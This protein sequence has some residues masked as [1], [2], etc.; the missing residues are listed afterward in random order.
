MF[1]AHQ[2]GDCFNRE[3]FFKARALTIEATKQI[4]ALVVPGMTE[5]DGHAL[6]NEVLA[7][8]GATKFW[9]P[10]KF[11]IGPNT[12]MSFREAST[13]GIKLKSDD[14]FFIDIG[15]VFL[16]HEG[17]YGETFVIGDRLEYFDIANASKKIFGN[18]KKVWQDKALSGQELFVFAEEE[19]RRQGYK[20][21]LKMKGHRIGDFPH[22][23]HHKGPLS[24]LE[25]CPV[26][27][28]WVLE[29]LIRHPEFEYGAFF[30]DILE[31]LA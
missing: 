7:K 18:V 12:L 23:I 20:L 3:Q 16:D 31:K 10:H 8:K 2:V 22:A 5:A 17:D 6:I 26:S 9:H 25:G 11:R 21:N 28:L 19:A 4:A 14:L 27:D 30:E 1:Q 29:I 24:E 15:P 13:P